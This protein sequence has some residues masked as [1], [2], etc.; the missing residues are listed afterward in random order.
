M[1]DY[2]ATERGQYIDA[3]LRNIDWAIVER[4]L[5]EEAAVRRAA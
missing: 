5:N 3:F 4:R 2:K 1:R